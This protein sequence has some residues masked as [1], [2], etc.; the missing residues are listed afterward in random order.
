[1]DLTKAGYGT[2]SKRGAETA[3]KLFSLVESCKLNKIN[4]RLYFKKLTS[5]LLAGKPPFTPS[6]FDEREKT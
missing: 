2:H 4:P 5:E 3:S 1:V 6:E